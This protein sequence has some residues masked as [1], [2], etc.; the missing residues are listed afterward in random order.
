VARRYAPPK[1]LPRDPGA[2]AV[3][4]QRQL[5]AVAQVLAEL[6]PEPGELDAL[7][8]EV[9]AVAA[10]ST[11]RLSPPAAGQTVVFPGAD[12][13]NR[14]KTIRLLVVAPQG[15]LT[16]RPLE[17]T[18]NGEAALTTTAYGAIELRSDGLGDWLTSSNPL[19]AAEGAELDFAPTDATYLV[20]SAHADLPN[21]RAAV[22]SPEIAPSFS[23]AGVVS[24]AIVTASIALSKLADLAGLSVLGRASNT[25]GVM[26]AITATTADTLLR[27]NAAG[28]ALEWGQATTGSYTDASVTL[29]KLATQ[30]DDTFLANISG[31]AAPPTAVPL[32]TLAGDGLTGGANAVLAVGAGSRI[33]VNANDVAWTGFDLDVNGASSADGWIGIDAIDSA[34]IDWFL[35]SPGAGM[36]GLS[37]IVTADLAA[38]LVNGNNSGVSNLH[39]DSG[40]YIGFGVEASLP[41]SGDIRASSSFLLN[42]QG[43]V[44]IAAGSGGAGDFSAA[45]DNVLIVS[46]GVAGDI[47]VDSAGTLELEAAQDVTIGAGSGGVALGSAGGVRIAGDSSTFTTGGALYFN[48]DSAAFSAAAGDGIL[49]VLNLAPNAAMFTDDEDASWALGYACV[50][51]NTTTPTATSATT[52]LSMGGSF[53]IPSNTARAGTIYR[54]TGQYVYVHTAA[55][56][57]TLTFEILIN[58]VVVS[59]VVLTP[60][61]VAS[62]YTGWFESTIRF[63]TVGAAGTA[64]VTWR[65]AGDMHTGYQNAITSSPTT[66]TVAVDTTLVRSIQTRVRMTTAVASNTLT[67]TQGYIERLA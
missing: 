40:Q 56:T 55:A 16:L 17:D 6:D 10:G 63:Q 29:P 8:D 23:I 33:T 30:A 53:N 51:T 60:V 20:Q 39:M 3:E 31:G 14:G 22:A 46:N 34:T 47:V 59:S 50:S 15:T 58:S 41:A 52:N 57:P 13:S 66:A 2:L 24:W 38:I 42:A 61:S 28:T 62:T 21:A 9:V 1:A 26:A 43:A 25:S 27:V 48:E 7:T 32:T 36:L 64:M 11:T 18:V 45:G 37:A 54:T 65:Q 35:S 4:L 67:V 44:S 12:P 5:D 49:W 19:P